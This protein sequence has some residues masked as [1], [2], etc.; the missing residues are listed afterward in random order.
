[1]KTEDSSEAEDSTFHRARDRKHPSHP[2]YSLLE[3]NSS[4]RE[5]CTKHDAERFLS[6]RKAADHLC[7]TYHDKAQSNQP[8]IWASP[9]NPPDTT[10]PNPANL[11]VTREYVSAEEMEAENTWPLSGTRLKDWDLAMIVLANE[12]S[13]EERASRWPLDFDEDGCVR[14]SR[15]PVGDPVIVV[16][17]GLPWY[18]V[19]GRYYIL[20]GD[21]SSNWLLN[22]PGKSGSDM[23][24]WLG[25]VVP[26]NDRIAGNKRYLPIHKAFVKN[27]PSFPD[28]EKG[29]FFLRH[30]SII[31]VNSIKGYG[32]RSKKSIATPDIVRK[33]DAV[34]FTVGNDYYKAPL[35]ESSWYTASSFRLLAQNYSV[36]D[37]PDETPG[38]DLTS[39]PFASLMTRR[40]E[41]ESPSSPSLSDLLDSDASARIAAE[42]AATEARIRIS[43][44]ISGYANFDFDDL[45]D[46]SL[47]AAVMSLGYK[48]ENLCRVM[49]THPD[50][51]SRAWIK[52]SQVMDAEIQD[53]R[54]LYNFIKMEVKKDSDLTDGQKDAYKRLLQGVREKLPGI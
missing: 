25:L 8:I 54:A 2:T 4:T 32:A 50:A 27:F 17:R 35:Q 19:F 36:S 10:N 30:N 42:K 12:P 7:S 51:D 15:V 31:D 39:D 22:F 46:T 41:S 48:V 1:M 47:R 49:N 43:E 16:W 37:T 13:L 23:T 28:F 3:M 45:P 6:W 52:E 29:G 18:P 26:T 33:R 14:P 44:S 40:R 34:I 5:I 21:G 20:S 11:P 9:R 53:V 38:P 24:L